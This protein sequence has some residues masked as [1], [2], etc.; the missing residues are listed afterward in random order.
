VQAAEHLE[1]VDRRVLAFSFDAEDAVFEAV[2]V[3][4]AARGGKLLADDLVLGV[5]GLDLGEVPV[6][7]VPC[8]L[9]GAR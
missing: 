2:V 1:Q 4:V 6:V 3:R 9:G 5:P 8:P 7:V